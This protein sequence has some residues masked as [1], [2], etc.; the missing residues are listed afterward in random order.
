MCRFL[1]ICLVIISRLYSDEVYV[2]GSLKCYVDQ[3]KRPTSLDIPFT[4][5]DIDSFLDDLGQSDDDEVRNISQLFRYQRSNLD[6]EGKITQVWN[7]LT[8]QSK[9]ARDYTPY[10]ISDNHFL[11]STLDDLFGF[12]RITKNEQSMRDAGFLLVP[13]Q[14]RSYMT[15][16]FHSL[17]PGHILKL[18]LDT[19]IRLKDG[20]SGSVWLIQR[21]QT[22]SMIRRLIEKYQIKRFT[23][24]SKYLYELPTKRSN[25][26][27]N[28]NPSLILLV[29]DM[30]LTSGEE[31][32]D[33]WKNK[34]TYE[35]LD[36]LYCI[37]SHGYGS[38]YVGPNVPL[39]KS[40]LY[41]FI[42]T[43]YPKRDIKYSQVKIFLSEPMKEYWDRLVR[44]GGKKHK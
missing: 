23:V 27:E 10:L 20:K 22:A 30:N 21:C 9:G 34:I 40:G 13:P 3:N 19:E 31:S 12:S 2:M 1:V 32:T 7:R 39:T 4:D 36:E 37:L 16:A 41:A 18:Y 42:D 44:S 15:L 17:L 38:A 29:E 14:H 43:E 24:P 6:L 28:K 35:H 33:S 8:T 25:G 26:K 11:K 5:E